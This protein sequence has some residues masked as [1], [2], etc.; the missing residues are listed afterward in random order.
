[1]QFTNRIY[2]NGE[3]FLPEKIIRGPVLSVATEEPITIPIQAMVMPPVEISIN[4][5][6]PTLFIKKT[7]IRVATILTEA[8]MRERLVAMLVSPLKIFVKKLT[9]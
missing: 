9:E 6:R 2:Y 4:P 5:F 7:A 3:D 8:S 1:M